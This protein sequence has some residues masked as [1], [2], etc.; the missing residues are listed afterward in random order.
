MNANAMN[1]MRDKKKEKVINYKVQLRTAAQHCSTITMAQ[2][3][4]DCYPVNLHIPEH[5]GTSRG[6][7]SNLLMQCM[8]LG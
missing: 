3:R 6:R 2:L 8:R 7:S 4:G 5:S 1:K